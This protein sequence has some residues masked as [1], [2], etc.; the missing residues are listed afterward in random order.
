VI[1]LPTHHF[2]VHVDRYPTDADLDAFHE[3]CSDGTFSVE[4]VDG[5]ADPVALVY[6]EREAE[7]EVDA[8]N[9]ARHDLTVAGFDVGFAARDVETLLKVIH[10]TSILNEGC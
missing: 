5:L 4:R 3:R 8:L 9:S 2:V 1:P 10:A 6:F 7:F